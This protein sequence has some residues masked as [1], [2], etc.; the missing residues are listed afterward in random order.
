[1]KAQHHRLVPPR[2]VNVPVSA[3][4]DAGLADGPARTYARLC[5][6]AWESRDEDK[7][8]P[9]LTVE[10]LAALCNLRRS[11]IWL[12]L[13]ILRDLGYV[14]WRTTR[15]R[16][17]IR[18][19]NNSVQNFGLTSHDAADVVDENL[20]QQQQQQTVVQNSELVQSFGL[21]QN[22]GLEANAALNLAALGEYGVDNSPYALEV[23]ALAHVTP[24]LVRAWGEYLRARP[25][26]S[27]LPGLLLHVLRNNT[28]PP[29][30]EERRGGP[31]ARARVELPE[32]VDSALVDIGLTGNRA[33]QEVADAF[34]ADPE[35]VRAWLEYV[36]RQRSSLSNAA[37][38]LLEMLRN[39]GVPPAAPAA[40]DVDR[41]RYISGEYADLIQH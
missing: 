23:A 11:A 8:T 1:M 27:N 9:P 4:F 12:H 39:G 22:S 2:Y 40:V 19:L 20:I 31:R 17:V 35:R 41:R 37:G 33:W 34:A 10:E 24:D 15:G 14:E 29:R 36:R 7:A 13:R 26:V 21:V 28:C 30:G 38:F 25:G 3:V 16:L 6:L 32:D 18:I 5:G